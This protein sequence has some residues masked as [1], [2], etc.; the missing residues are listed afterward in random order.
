MP[1]IPRLIA[2]LWKE[3]PRAHCRIYPLFNKLLYFVAVMSMKKYKRKRM[4]W[5]NIFREKV[6]YDSVYLP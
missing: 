1:I 2:N 3:A 6:R 5:F 4:D